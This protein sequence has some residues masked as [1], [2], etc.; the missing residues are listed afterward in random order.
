MLYFWIEINGG[1][2]YTTL[3]CSILYLMIRY[4][5]KQTSA[6]ILSLIPQESH[7][8]I[9]F[10]TKAQ[11]QTILWDSLYFNKLFFWHEQYVQGQYCF[12]WQLFQVRRRMGR[13]IWETKK[14]VI[15]SFQEHRWVYS[16]SHIFGLKNVLGLISVQWNHISCHGFVWGRISWRTT[17]SY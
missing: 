15:V 12:S 2:H 6:T 11:I 10:S 14:D 5:S 7:W 16:W 1:K 9:I 8:T 13:C 17:E 4:L 3:F